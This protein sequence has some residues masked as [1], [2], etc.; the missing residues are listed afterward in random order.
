V[1]I[2]FRD[3]GIVVINVLTVPPAGIYQGVAPNP[4]TLPPAS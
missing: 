3:A 4:P 2:Q 1:K